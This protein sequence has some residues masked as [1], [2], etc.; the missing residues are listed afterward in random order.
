MKI[1]KLLIGLVGLV[2]LTTGINA[3]LY[4]YTYNGT[5]SY[6]ATSDWIVER[7]PGGI[8]LV[9]GIYDSFVSPIEASYASSHY[10]TIS[11]VSPPGTVDSS[12]GSMM[13]TVYNRLPQSSFG[14]DVTFVS[15][16]TSNQ[17]K[18]LG[19]IK[20]VVN[21]VLSS[22]SGTSPLNGGQVTL[23]G[24]YLAG[25]YDN[26]YPPSTSVTV[27]GV[28]AS[29]VSVTKTAMVISTP[30]LTSTGSKTVQV[31]YPTVT[32]STSMTYDSLPTFDTPTLVSGS[33]FP[34][35]GGTLTVYGAKFGTSASVWKLTNGG[36]TITANG[37]ASTDTSQS[38][39]RVTFAI[40]SSSTYTSQADWTLS[41][42]LG[43][44]V[45]LKIPIN[46]FHW[47]ATP[48]EYT[49][50]YLFTTSISGPWASGSNPSVTYLLSRRGYNVVVTANYGSIPS[51]T[52]TSS[53]GVSTVTILPERFRPS[54]V[55]RCYNHVVVAGVGYDAHAD[56]ENTGFIRYHYLSSGASYTSSP[57]VLTGTCQWVLSK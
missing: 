13:Q 26:Y 18:F 52:F 12:T 36:T 33:T 47:L 50:N 46:Y 17:L 42:I 45:N 11:L 15:S 37:I 8:S 21:P 57:T 44:T 6:P 49:E 3:T 14:Y 19:L 10:N 24:N 5:G 7:I 35:S 28:A 38:Y 9:W 4:T 56:Y 39:S 27:G 40:P 51:P 41:W 30:S 48:I 23:V 43:S 31:I 34:M 53:A 20:E 25:S 32:V 29:I 22:V 55:I 54:Y 1:A 16:A 2:L